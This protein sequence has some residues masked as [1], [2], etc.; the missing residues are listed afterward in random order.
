MNAPVGP[1]HVRATLAQVADAG[2]LA[3]AWEDVLAS[4]RVDGVLGPG[5]THFAQ[6]ADHLAEL[7]AQLQSGSHQ[8]G[9]LAPVALPRPDGQER[10]LH[11]PTVRDRIVERSIL[12]VLT[13]LIDPWLGPFSYAYRPGLGV[14][15]AVQAIA[16]LRDEGMCWVARADFHDCFGTIPVSRLRR[17][18]ALLIE[19][20][21]LL[22]LIETL[23]NRRAAAGGSAAV[24][25]GLPQGSPLSPLWANLV[26]AG[27][28]TRVARTGLPPGAVLRRS[29]GPG[30]QS[31]RRLGGDASHE[32]GSQ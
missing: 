4:D 6:D 3:T 27:F 9:R 30:G 24:V 32:R 14:A 20:P 19:D 21:G 28:D 1:S 13:P 26:L 8:P 7:A 16:R 10:V 5:V 25:K 15:D 22:A 2:Q 18:L 17:M 11:I 12:A 29:G 23:L 31:R